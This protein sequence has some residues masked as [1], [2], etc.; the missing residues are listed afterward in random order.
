MGNIVSHD[1]ECLLPD[2]LGHLQTR[3]C[4]YTLLSSWK[5]RRVLKLHQEWPQDGAAAVHSVRRRRLREQFFFDAALYVSRLVRD[6]VDL[7][8]PEAL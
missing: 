5:T 8:L 3:A 7:L 4:L 2:Q 1:T 6:A